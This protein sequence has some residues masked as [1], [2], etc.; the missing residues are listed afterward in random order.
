MNT[1]LFDG[2]QLD[3]EM[4]GLLGVY[5]MAVSTKIDVVDQKLLL[6]VQAALKLYHEVA[7]STISHSE[8]T[9]DASCELLSLIALIANSNGFGRCLSH[10]EGYLMSRYTIIRSRNR[11]AGAWHAGHHRSYSSCLVEIFTSMQ[12][13][14]AALRMCCL[15]RSTLSPYAS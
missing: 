12:S 14:E 3:Y 4:R 2:R 9:P 8:F 10:E 13:A 7:F 5:I 6:I 15:S 1:I 11:D